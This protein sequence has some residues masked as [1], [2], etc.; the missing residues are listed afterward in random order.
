MNEIER[1]SELYQRAYGGSAWHGPALRDLLS[2]VSAEEASATLVPGGHSIWRWVRHLIAWQDF[3]TR[4]LKG[5]A[6]SEPAEDE[7]WPEITD[8]GEEAWS[9]TLVELRESQRAFRLALEA[10]DPA[11]LGHIVP[12]HTYRFDRLLYGIIHHMI[13]HAGQIALIK[14]MWTEQQG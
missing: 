10:F 6:A 8:Q 3:A 5:G 2:D 4:L 11:K 7:S 14:R 1:L 12:G 9:R 13:Y